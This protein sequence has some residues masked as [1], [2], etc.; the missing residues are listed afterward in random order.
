MSKPADKVDSYSSVTT[1]EDE[2]DSE[3]GSPILKKIRF[4]EILKDECLLQQMKNSDNQMNSI[5]Y[6]VYFRETGA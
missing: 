1:S 5:A 4:G 3:I 6:H 2:Q